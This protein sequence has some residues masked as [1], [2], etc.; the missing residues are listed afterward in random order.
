MCA[1]VPGELELPRFRLPRQARAADREAQRCSSARPSD[2]P[3]AGRHAAGDWVEA[4]MR[5]ADLDQFGLWLAGHCAGSL[6]GGM[7]RGNGQRTILLEF[8]GITNVVG[9]LHLVHPIGHVVRSFPFV[10]VSDAE[11][12]RRSCRRRRGRGPNQHGLSR[13]D[14]YR[15]SPQLLHDL[16]DLSQMRRTDRLTLTDKASVGVD[17]LRAPMSVTP[18]S[19]GTNSGRGWR[20]L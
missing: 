11:S 4:R 16:D 2:T 12:S 1:G 14:A 7:P 10:A 20:L 9:N 15:F 17:G 19:I 13:S 8:V 5:R 18:R 3:S 6:H